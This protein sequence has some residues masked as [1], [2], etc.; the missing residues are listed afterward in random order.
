MRK[1]PESDP[2]LLQF[3]EAPSQKSV[4][5]FINEIPKITKEAIMLIHSY[6]NNKKI[7]L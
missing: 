1:F 3:N 5:T 7:K 6:Q 4:F 2:V